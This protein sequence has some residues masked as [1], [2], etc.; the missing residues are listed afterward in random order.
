MG[1]SDYLAMRKLEKEATDIRQTLRNDRMTA[2]QAKE[3]M[4]KGGPNGG[5]ADYRKV[6]GGKTLTDAER[7]KLEKEAKTA[8]K[9]IKAEAKAAEKKI[10]EAKAAEKK[11]KEAKRQ[12]KGK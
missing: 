2:D 6:R 12:S 5:K 10:K 11:I 7:R 1:L 3:H 8:E 4:K 9:K